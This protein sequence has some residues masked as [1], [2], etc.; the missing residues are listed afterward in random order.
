[1]DS[2]GFPKD[3]YHY[4]RAWWGAKPALH[5]FPHWN[6]AGREGQ[7]IAVWVHSNCD[8]VEL[9]LNGHSL[10]HQSVTRN[11]HLEWQVP[12]APGRIEAHAFARG[13]HILTEVRETTG[14]P[15]RIGLTSD[16][17]SLAPGEVAVVRAAI[18]DA[19]RREVPTASN[20]VT[21]TLDGDATLLGVAMA[22][23]AASN[24]TMPALARR[25]MACAW[26]SSRRASAAARS[27]SPRRAMA[28]M[29][30]C[31]RSS[32]HA[33]DALRSYR[34]L[35]SIDRDPPMIPLRAKAL[36]L[37]IAALCFPAKVLAAPDAA[38]FT[39]SIGLREQWQYLTRDVA[40][41]ARWTAD[42]GHFFY[43]KTVEGASPSRR[44]IA[45]LSPNRR[46]SIR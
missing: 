7:E 6:W 12:Y 31:C 30:R 14:T 37:A 10:G 16:R 9:F 19:K 11:R 23:R 18:L 24:P 38:A 36:V 32:R 26:R 41:P 46:R 2:C 40:W 43:R 15:H 34:T 45:E 20:R 27:A 33:L 25:S 8:T 28:S 4:Y 13:R 5:L 17:R 22:T 42:G 21:F 1:M 35:L 29:P 39:R 44:S 3:N